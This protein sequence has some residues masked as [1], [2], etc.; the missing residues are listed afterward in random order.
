MAAERPGPSVYSIAA[1]RGFADA[2]VAG[3]IPRYGDKD[4]G[5]ARLTLL[6]PS[7][8]AVRTV[9]EAFV[10]LSEGGMLL[11][12]MVPVGDL[13]LEEAL[14]PLLDPLGAGADIPPAVN[15]THRWLRLA[16]L[17]R[18]EMGKNA[19]HD[20][21]LLRLAFDLGRTI[22]R[23]TVEGL[24]LGDLLSERVAGIVG[25][26]AEHWRESTRLFAR[27]LAGWQAELGARGEVDPPARR[28]LLFAHA[29]RC[30]R[31]TPPAGPVVA[32]GV[33]SAS[34]ALAALLR[35]VADLP[36]GAVILPDLD[37]ALPDAVWEQLGRAGRPPA[38][39]EAPF[40]AHDAVTHPQYHLKLLLER[41]GVARAEVDP[42]HRAGLSAA[43]PERSRAISNLFLPAAASAGWI[44]LPAAQRR[45]SGVRVMESAHPEE[46]AQAI[47]ILVRAALEDPGK[48]VAVIT[49]DRGL[50]G[51]IVA[52]LR[53]WDIAA[54][55]SA[56]R[57]L[58]QTAAGR[59]LLQLAEVVMTEAAPV[60]LLALLHHPLVQD[61]ESRAQWL[62]HARRFDL[63]LRG[64]RP[65]PGL[66]P[67]QAAADKA[68]R[69]GGGAGLRAWWE[70]VEAILRP[71]LDAPDPAP[72]GAVLDRLVSAGEALCGVRL[73]S[74]PDGRALS[75]LVDDLR[76]A[77]AD[78]ATM[79]ARADL[80]AVLRDAMDRVAVRPQWGQ[81]PRVAI[82]G[83][84]E[85]RMSRADLVICA[86]LSEG[87]WPAAPGAE[88]LLPPAV[89]RA[90]G[91]PGGEFR[92]GL[93][94]HD[95]AGAL[96]APE[97]VLSWARRDDSGPVIASRF[98]LRVEAMLGEL[99]RDHR[100]TAAVELARS[101][102]FAS[103]A[104]PY[105]RPAPD[106]TPEQRDVPL[107]VTAIDRLRGDPY[108]F[109]ASAI[110]RLR[111]L[112]PLDAEPTAAWK[113]TVVHR[114]LE[115][116]HEAG[117]GAGELLALAQAELAEM[118]AH[119]L[120]RTLW[121]PRL[122]RGLEWIDAQVKAQRAEG[123]EVVASE[124]DGAMIR[125]GVKVFGR[126]DR[127]DR[128]ADGALAIV[129]YKT[130]KPPSG[131]MVQDG[132]A[133]QLGTLGLIAEA[134]GFTGLAG[135][136]E[137][138]EYWSLGKARDSD[139]GFGYVQ[140]PILEGRA[141]SGLPRAEFLDTIAGFLDGAIADW[142][143][144]RRPFTARLNPDIG[145]YND[146]D[147]LMRLDEWQARAAGTENA[148]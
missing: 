57:P 34:P 49:P 117:G 143:K 139:T 38:E 119:P 146:Y 102:D 91:V 82:Y 145:G 52:H 148:A 25:E 130:G 21:G 71:L 69:R 35:T 108:Q 3:L 31:E 110:L 33:T 42:W 94:A 75:C 41:M 58:P 19:P 97:V 14:G 6:L 79:I 107:A 2:L 90:L 88:P 67:L 47:A 30:W 53:R 15:P 138:F 62:D 89:L 16:A 65:A 51:R 26:L 8:R 100:E 127:I 66:A 121:W 46:Q 136:A 74:G 59:L 106:P 128:L 83:L 84:L 137:G 85:A 144:G 112:D 40:G 135:T 124:Q 7:Q 32:A 123:R 45:L 1:H 105:P 86:G 101:I 142:I 37:L 70:S 140:E 81:H 147:Q 111:K 76:S 113:G 20:P 114:V 141:K 56:G 27:V 92:I 44:D 36:G 9:T 18:D 10:R 109:Y 5:L 132:F 24:D 98:V 55:D 96:G 104:P 12:R 68:E 118:R 11:P 17:L 22:D 103:P 4:L 73:W 50:A 120:V 93:A 80:P 39:G 134:G 99:A 28:N 78:G 133:L 87:T 95:L 29:A 48:R 72:L 23:L 54:D 77:A 60:P 126:V 131:K 115:R 125:H 116:W 43:P 122:A 64:P 13:D 129:D 61:G 63:A